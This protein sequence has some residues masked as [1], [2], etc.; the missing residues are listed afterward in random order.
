VAVEWNQNPARLE[1]GTRDR[2][3]YSGFD[4]LVAYWLGRTHGFVAADA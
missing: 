2:G 3:A 1:P 4:Y